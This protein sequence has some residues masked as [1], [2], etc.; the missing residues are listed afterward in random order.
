MTAT[1]MTALSAAVLIAVAMAGSVRAADFM[2]D[3]TA[4]YIQT[5]KIPAQEAGVL[6][7]VNVRDGDRAQ[8][9]DLLAKIDDRQAQA[10]KK[11]AEV[12][13][14]AAEKRGNDTIEI[15]YAKAA[16][17]VAWIDW[18]RDRQVNL[19]SAGTIPDIQI[20]QKELVYRK[21]LLQH[22]KALNDQVL[23]KMDADVYRAELEQAELALERRE[24]RAPFDGEV[25]TLNIR[26]SEWVN[27]GDPIMEYVR[28]DN[29]Y[30]DF[31]VD[32]EQY[33][34]IDLEGLAVTVTVR[35]ARSETVDLQGKI[36]SIDPT[37]Q[38]LTQTFTY[39]VRAEVENSKPRGFWVLRDNMPVVVT[40]HT[41]Q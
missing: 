17:E 8:A 18:D 40:V 16:G 30:V 28:L 3:G 22:E 21:S 37:V 14:A 6:Q 38:G 31:N 23:A 35:L 32:G 12:K 41:G 26:Q 2:A 4:A 5:I 36:V 1:R 11:V 33:D 27:P 9:G 19:A 20:R 10:A 24:I 39:Q 34:P 13:L 7:E 15:R 29:L 25:K